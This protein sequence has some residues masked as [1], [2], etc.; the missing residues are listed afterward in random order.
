VLSGTLL[1]I[2]GFGECLAVV[3]SLWQM[4]SFHK[5]MERSGSLSGMLMLNRSK[6]S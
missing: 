5:N 3:H 2:L 1:K 4:F 6:I